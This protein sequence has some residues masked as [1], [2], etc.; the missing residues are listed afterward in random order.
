MIK[1][2]PYAINLPCIALLAIFVLLASFVRQA[3][4]AD[5]SP[6]QKVVAKVDTKTYLSL[7]DAKNGQEE[8]VELLAPIEYMSRRDLNEVGEVIEAKDGWLHIAASISDADS[9]WVKAADMTPLDDF[10]ADPANSAITQCP[11]SLVRHF[12]ADLAPDLKQAVIRITTSPTIDGGNGVLEV[13]TPDE[14]K[15]IWSTKDQPEDLIARLD[16]DCNRLIMHWP[17]IIGDIDGD[18]FAELLYTE[19]PLSYPDGTFSIYKWDGKAF[20]EQPY[21]RVLAVSGPEMP[22]TATLHEVADYQGNETPYF[23]LADFRG[24]D[25]AGVITA[26]IYLSG[27]D[28]NES[29][30]ARFTLSDNCS[31]FT[32]IEWLSP[33]AKI[34]Q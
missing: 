23:F 13:L 17:Q 11:S 4:A 30:I 5:F 1:T 34:T 8:P 21:N 12:V 19:F 10:L 9:L 20:V 7:E 33:P 24:V 32:F 18:G 26:E 31:K 14:S 15:V 3:A 27:A 29:G 6:G 22:A 2:K 28:S 16:I 25:A